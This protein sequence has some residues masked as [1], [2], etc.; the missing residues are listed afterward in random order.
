MKYI[1]ERR[2]LTSERASESPERKPDN[3]WGAM[4]EGGIRGAMG[5]GASGVGSEWNLECRVKELWYIILAFTWT[6]FTERYHVC[7][8][9]VSCTLVWVG[10]IIALESGT[11]WYSTAEIHGSELL[12][13]RYTYP[14]TLCYSTAEVLYG[15]VA[16]LW[17]GVEKVI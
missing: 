5:G 12:Y 8:S 17:Y 1:A 4:G 13:G 10:H 2:D 14:R 7:V 3:S 16:G 9:W 11:L 6:E 15:T